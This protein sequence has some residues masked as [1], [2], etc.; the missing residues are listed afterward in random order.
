[1]PDTIVPVVRRPVRRVSATPDPKELTKDVRKLSIGED[2]SRAPE[3]LR[4]TWNSETGRSMVTPELERRKNLTGQVEVKKKE[5]EKEEK[6]S[7]RKELEEDVKEAKKSVTGYSGFPYVSKDNLPTLTVAKN[8][9]IK[10]SKDLELERTLMKWLELVAGKKPEPESFDR[11]IQDGS[12]LAKAMISVSFNSVP[13]EMVNCNWGASPVRD[14]IKSVI[15]EM[16][17]Y[18]VSEVFDVEDLMELKNMPKVCKAVARLCRLAAADSK[19]DV[20]KSI[21]RNLPIF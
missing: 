16:R 17:R 5:K 14:R 8:R 21:A 18:G 20:L 2:S 7:I 19:S 11:W 15:H 1:M 6:P 9:A 4:R 12:I 13:L 3:R 10:T